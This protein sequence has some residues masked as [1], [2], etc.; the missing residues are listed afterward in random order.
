[1]RFVDAQ[2]KADVERTIDTLISQKS[3]SFARMGVEDMFA[4]PGYRAFY[5]DVATDHNVRALT[6]VSRLEVGATIG[7]LVV[8]NAVG[9]G[10]A[11]LQNHRLPVALR[12][13]A[14]R[15]REYLDADTLREVVRWLDALDRQ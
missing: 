15:G 9:E 13:I 3:R 14:N 10:K 8:V 1:M 11:K 7:V 2:D 4:R 6:H 5:L 12:E